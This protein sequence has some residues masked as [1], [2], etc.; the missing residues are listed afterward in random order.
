MTTDV[1]AAV[2][3]SCENLCRAT[4]LIS[5]NFMLYFS[6]SVSN[7]FLLYAMTYGI[8]FSSVACILK[9]ESGLG[10]MHVIGFSMVAF[11]SLLSMKDF[12]STLFSIDIE[13]VV[14]ADQYFFAAGSIVQ[15]LAF[16]L[17]STHDKRPVLFL[18]VLLLVENIAIPILSLNFVL[19]CSGLLVILLSSICIVNP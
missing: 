10:R 18:S 14:H 11:I 17:V 9:G 8:I 13:S 5:G 7:C 15:I 2:K 19:W 4:I 3:S 6:M 16:L 12:S 1:R